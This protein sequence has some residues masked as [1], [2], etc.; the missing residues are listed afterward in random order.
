MVWLC[1]LLPYGQAAEVMRRIGKRAVADSSLWRAT[2]KVGR[3][4]CDQ[5]AHLAKESILV[6]RPSESAEPVTKLLSM[7]G[8]MVNI[9]GEGWKELKVGPG[10][11]A[12]SVE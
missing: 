8:G 11:D 3:V 1:R 4:M 6:F 2:Q 7:D 10:R 12:E 5:T 9:E